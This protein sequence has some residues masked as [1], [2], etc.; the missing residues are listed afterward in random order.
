MYSVSWFFADLQCSEEEFYCYHSRT[1]ISRHLR[2]DSQR[3]CLNGEDERN[4][5]KW[6]NFGNK[7]LKNILLYRIKMKK[8]V[9]AFH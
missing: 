9:I 7:T 3:D 4:C 5:C 1:C 8:K 6:N 2:C